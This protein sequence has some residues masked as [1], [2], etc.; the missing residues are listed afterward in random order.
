MT[1]QTSQPDQLSLAN[2]DQRVGAISN[3]QFNEYWAMY[4]HRVSNKTVP[5][6]FVE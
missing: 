5:V 2:H 3:G 6:L 4:V 1:T